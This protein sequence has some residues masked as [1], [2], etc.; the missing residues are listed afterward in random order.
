MLILLADDL[1]TPALQEQVIKNCK[2]P[3]KHSAE[4]C[5]LSALYSTLPRRDK[6][7]VRDGTVHPQNSY[8][9]ALNP[10]VAIFG[11]GALEEVINVKWGHRVGP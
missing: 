11:D 8:A 10:N 1:A 2:Y 6:N 5:P 9:E 7:G 3:Q 4:G